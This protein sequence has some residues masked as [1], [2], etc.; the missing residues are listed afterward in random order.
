MTFVIELSGIDKKSAS[1]K[2][3]TFRPDQLV[4]I[5]DSIR[6]VLALKRVSLIKSDIVQSTTRERNSLSGVRVIGSL[7]SG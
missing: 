1:T 3:T 7:L 2:N 4:F 5:A 6:Q